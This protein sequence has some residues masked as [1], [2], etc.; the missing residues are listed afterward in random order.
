MSGAGDALGGGKWWDAYFDGVS[1]GEVAQ[2]GDAE[3]NGVGD[4]GSGRDHLGG[5]DKPGVEGFEGGSEFVRV[6]CGGHKVCF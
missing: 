3:A 2:V 6:G 5:V 1:G 4:G